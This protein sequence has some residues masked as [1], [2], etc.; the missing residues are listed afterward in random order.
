MHAKL[1]FRLV[2]TASSTALDDYPCALQ[3]NMGSYSGVLG[4]VR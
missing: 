2:N 3:H 1:S 4:T